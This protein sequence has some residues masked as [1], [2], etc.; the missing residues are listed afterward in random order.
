MSDFTKALLLLIS[1]RHFLVVTAA[2]LV[3]G[4]FVFTG[5]IPADQFVDTVK[6][7]SALLA[8]LYGA[9]HV[10]LAARNPPPPSS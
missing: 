6:Q 1:S 3:S 4:V 9:E 5:K 10:A 7:F 2:I 8:V